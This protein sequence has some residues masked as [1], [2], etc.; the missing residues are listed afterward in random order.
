VEV[1]GCVRM[2]EC[3]SLRHDPATKQV[4]IPNLWVHGKL[5]W[6]RVSLAMGGM[7]GGQNKNTPSEVHD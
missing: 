1:L 5:T 7:E 6:S 2:C 3:V 4:K